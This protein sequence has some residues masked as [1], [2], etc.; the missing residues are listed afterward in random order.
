MIIPGRAQCKC[1]LDEYIHHAK[2]GKFNRKQYNRSKETERVCAPFDS[3]KKL[4]DSIPE[5]ARKNEAL[6]V[7][8]FLWI[9]VCLGLKGFLPPKLSCQKQYTSN[10]KAYNYLVSPMVRNTLH[11]SPFCWPPVIKSCSHLFFSVTH[12][13]ITENSIYI[14][15][16]FFEKSRK[17]PVFF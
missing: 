2:T 12:G 9:K 7:C 1:F 5:P 3:I 8:C 17:V 14:L 15:S 11:S 10:D 16:R 6:F 4:A 13:P